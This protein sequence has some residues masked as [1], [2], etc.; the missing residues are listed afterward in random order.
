MTV[1]KIQIRYWNELFSLL[2]NKCQQI[3]EDIL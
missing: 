3:E 1:M 2:Q